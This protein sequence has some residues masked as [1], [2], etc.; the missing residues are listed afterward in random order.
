[1]QEKQSKQKAK[2]GGGTSNTGQRTKTEAPLS[3]PSAKEQATSRAIRHADKPQASS[4][5]Y[6]PMAITFALPSDWK[7]GEIYT[8]EPDTGQRGANTLILWS[9][10]AKQG[11]Q[12]GSV[13]KGYFLG[14]QKTR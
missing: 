14:G 1:M 10:G 6:L 8:R 13:P 7:Q 5:F 3:Q 9:Y 2:G 11:E 12:Q 4:L